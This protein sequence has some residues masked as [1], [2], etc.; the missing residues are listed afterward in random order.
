MNRLLVGN[1]IFEV[2]ELPDLDMHQMDNGRIYEFLVSNHIGDNYPNA[3][4]LV[5]EPFWIA[6]H[7]DHPAAD[8]H[9]FVGTVKR[10]EKLSSSKRMMIFIELN[11]TV[12][13]CVDDGYQFP[14]IPISV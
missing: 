11:Y 6:V 9:R 13:G 10:V 12:E 7:F 2:V 14:N 1:E 4:A 8:I 5:N 3:A